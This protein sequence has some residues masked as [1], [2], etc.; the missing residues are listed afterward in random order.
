VSLSDAEIG[1]N[2]ARI[3]G[4]RSQADVAAAMRARG[5]KW[6][7]T[8]VWKVESGERPLRFVEASGLADVLGIGLSEFSLTTLDALIVRYVT[9]QQERERALAEAITAYLAGQREL[10]ACADFV[11]DETGFLDDEIAQRVTNL[12]TRSPEAIT[13]EARVTVR[14]ETESRESLRQ[15]QE[16]LHRAADSE[17]TV[18][19]PPLEELYAL[20]RD[21]RYAQVVDASWARPH[22]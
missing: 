7:Q 12:L 14:H 10:A 20:E 9:Q 17:A 15:Q 13:E 21:G 1:K 3:R 18:S 22:G 4:A 16:A 6:S 5:F 2:I 19:I 11:D 8:T